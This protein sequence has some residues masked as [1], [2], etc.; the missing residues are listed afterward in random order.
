MSR[1]SLLFLIL[2]LILTIACGRD[3]ST[4]GNTTQVE[5][6]KNPKA[7]PSV[8]MVVQ[9]GGGGLCT[10]TF[11]SPSAV[12]TAAHC[13][14]RYGKYTILSSFGTFFSYEFESIGFAGVTDTSDMSVLILAEPAASRQK[15]QVTPIATV[16]EPGEKVRLVGFG[17]DDL[18]LRTG[19]GVKRTGV[20]VVASVSNFV[21]LYSPFIPPPP[22]TRKILGPYDQAA[23]CF[24]D[25]GGPL[26]RTRDNELSIVGICHA[27]GHN[28]DTVLSQFININRNENI[29]FLYAIDDDYDLGIFDPCDPI[30]PM[31]YP[32]C[33]SRTASVQIVDFIKSVMGW[34]K[35][36]WTSFWLWLGL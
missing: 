10:G 31:P 13:T 8:V 5:V 33:G 17:C 19:A 26:L 9:P 7:F 3:Y 6:V 28:S 18:D 24:G 4:Y 32:T 36:A 16:A 12:L 35:S 29:D 23:T 14:R 20:N 30:D 22:P 27:G 21:E 15:G 25:S 34:V 1:C 2:T 11:I